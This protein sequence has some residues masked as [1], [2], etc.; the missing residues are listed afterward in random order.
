MDVDLKVY[1]SPSPLPHHFRT[2]EKVIVDDEGRVSFP[3]QA[4]KLHSY[5]YLRTHLGA[6]AIGLKVCES[7]ENWAKNKNY[8][9]CG[10]AQTKAKLWNILSINGGTVCAKE[11]WDYIKVVIHTIQATKLEDSHSIC[12]LRKTQKY[13]SNFNQFLE[14]ILNKSGLHL[15]LAIMTRATYVSANSKGEGRPDQSLTRRSQT[16]ETIETLMPK[17]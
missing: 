9:S 3:S 8:M 14:R 17:C 12:L 2:V 16:I 1:L 5:G 6:Q 10:V 15:K 13:S 11:F 7:F 4:I